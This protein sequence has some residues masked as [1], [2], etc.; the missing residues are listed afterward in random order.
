MLCLFAL[1]KIG[2]I[3][4]EWFSLRSENFGNNHRTNLGYQRGTFTSN[5]DR[6][7]ECNILDF[8]KTFTK[9]K[10]HTDNKMYYMKIYLI[11]ALQ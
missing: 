8:I 10:L 11:L 5:V 2:I 7:S 4:S 9:F 1:E 3:L 6:N